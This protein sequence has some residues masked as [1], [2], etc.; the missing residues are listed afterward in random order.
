M[1]AWIGHV[2]LADG[3]AALGAVMMFAAGG[4]T[5][6]IFED[7]APQVR[8]ERTWLPPLGAI[9]GFALGLGGHLLAQ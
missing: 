9:L 2:A 8:L 3:P 5:Y 6:L 4:I 7:I 1:A